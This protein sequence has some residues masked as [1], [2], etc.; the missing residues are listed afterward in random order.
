MKTINDWAEKK[1][2]NERFKI[3]EIAESEFM[4]FHSEISEAW[5]EVRKGYGIYDVYFPTF[6][7]ERMN[8]DTDFQLAQQG[9]KPEGIGVEIADLVIRIFHTCA[10]HKIPLEDLMIIKMAY[11]ETREYRHGGKKV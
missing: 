9:Y 6:D 3:E 4:N 2:W 5:E 11:N 10:F 8:T 1:G 7:K